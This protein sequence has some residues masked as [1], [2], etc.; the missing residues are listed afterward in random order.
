MP[1]AVRHSNELEMDDRKPT[2]SK[3]S[4]ERPLTSDGG[5]N[6]SILQGEM[7]DQST[8]PT[9]ISQRR[10]NSS[11]DPRLERRIVRKFDLFLLPFLC[12]LFLLNSLDRSNIGNAET[13][14]FTRDAGLQPE[15]L[16]TAVACF[17]TFFV[18]LQPVGAA[19]GRKVGMARWVPSVMAI[20][21]L[22]TALH[23][24]INKRWQ[25]ISVRILIGILEAGFYPTTVSYLSL[26]YTRYE[27]ARRLGFFYGQYA[28]AGAVG[29]I[30]SFIVFSY[31]PPSSS[32]DTQ[33]PSN[34]N[35]LLSRAE[36][37]SNIN[38]DGWKS[39]QVLFLLEGG[40]T[41]LIAL[42]GF[43]WLP[44]S[45]GDAW[46]LNR[47]EKEYAE[48]RIQ[49]DRTAQ[50]IDTTTFSDEE[51]L[52][53]EEEEGEEASSETSP[54]YQTD[55]TSSSQLSPLLL[56]PS[57]TT[58]QTSTQSPPPPPPPPQTD[59]GLPVSS[60]ISA[61]LSPHIYPLL[62]LNILSSIPSTAFSIF[63][64]LILT[65]LTPNSPYL[66]N[67]LTAPPF[68]VG[69]ITLLLFTH[70]SDTF[71]KR[72]TPLLLSLTL[73]LTGLLLTL[74]P[75][76]PLLHYLSL[77]LLLAGT[78]I[79]SP[80]TIAW[81]TDNTPSPSKRALLLGING[82]GNLAGVFSALIF[83]PDAAPRY[84]RPLWLTVGVTGVAL[85]GFGGFRKGVRWENRWRE[86]VLRGWGREGR[87]KERREGRGPRAE[88]RVR[89][90]VRGLVER[91]GGENVSDAREGDERLTFVYGL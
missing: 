62:A 9:L 45:A 81:L 16:N 36:G 56:T 23:V 2:D 41:I 77:H 20:W 89:A 87:E 12:I 33:P 61:L 63:L 47:E 71:H 24:W 54:L 43:L 21:G 44:H 51:S 19:A 31:F 64:P 50:D 75:L 18:L 70:Y 14:N 3:P 74:L 4:E 46:F 1:E 11:R 42:V 27:F 60:I 34:A 48:W 37:D 66:S 84:T 80:L 5:D 35:P 32:P 79:P 55:D 86:R 15:D 58:T 49:E 8:E 10:L 67:L 39:W 28:I 6:S 59:H 22:C 52:G 26:F 88:G 69:F 30:L 25:L 90:L 72:L 13:A 7:T 82:W 73:L 65:D 78:F 53:E 57:S 29:G 91:W 68:L 76:P 17:F 83:T 38:G 40:L 85:V